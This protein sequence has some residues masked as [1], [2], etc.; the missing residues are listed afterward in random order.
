MTKLI[1]MAAVLGLAV[2]LGGAPAHAQQMGDFDL[3]TISDV[4]LMVDASTPPFLVC[5]VKVWDAA[6]NANYSVISASGSVLITDPL[7]NY[8]TD[9]VFAMAPG[10]NNNG[11][12]PFGGTA[13]N[14]S[15]TGVAENWSRV[16]VVVEVRWRHY[17]TGQ[18]VTHRFSLP[19]YPIDLVY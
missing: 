13:G 17:M 18:V 11:L 1:P 19:D 8:Q 9:R 5:R 16:T 4:G 6:P 12:V 2:A 15:S 7:G 14:M 10:A 3:P